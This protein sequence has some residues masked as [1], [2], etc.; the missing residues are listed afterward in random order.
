MRLN[1]VVRIRL[2]KFQ[3]LPT[4]ELLGEIR[5]KRANGRNESSQ[6]EKMERMS[7]SERG[8]PGVSRKFI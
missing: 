6:H 4:V 7:D 3:M 2:L 5:C 1:D 8:T